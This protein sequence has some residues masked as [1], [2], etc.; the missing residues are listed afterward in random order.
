[1]HFDV[2]ADHSVKKK[3][4]KKE[5]KKKKKRKKI[6]KYLDLAKEIKNPKTKSVE[7]E[8]VGEISSS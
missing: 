3:K 5:K 1:M 6:R 4:K 2:P 7:H 8:G